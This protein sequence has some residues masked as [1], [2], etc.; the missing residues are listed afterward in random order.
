MIGGLVIFAL[1][2]A[3]QGLWQ[4][5]DTYY[6]RYTDTSVGGIQVGG[7]VVY[8]GIAVGSIQSIEIDPGDVESIIVEIQVQDGTPIKTDVVARIVPVGIT[9]ISQI[10]LSGG[11]QAA[12]EIDPGSFITPADSTFGQVT[13]SVTSILEGIEGVLSDIAQVLDRIDSDSIGNILARID[14]MLSDNED[15]V[16][17]LLQELNEAAAG[18]TGAT[19]EIGGLVSSVT[20]VSGDLELLVRRNGPEI[21]EAIESLNDTLRLLNNF[22]F[23][24]NNDPSLLIRPE[25]R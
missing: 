9:G 2:V 6:V 12:E 21:E 16:S 13:D 14:G 17:S 4:Q 1:I 23:Q 18:L 24:I 19:G 11:T 5:Y 20:E 10:E 3:G 7:T 15:T 8:Q 22:A 25:E